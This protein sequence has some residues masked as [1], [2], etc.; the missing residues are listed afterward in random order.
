MAEI[1]VARQGR[2]LVPVNDSDL[3]QLERLKHGTIYKA[4]VSAPRNLKRHRRFFALLNLTFG[5]WQPESMIASVEKST[6]ESLGKYLVRHGIAK[7]AV[8][9]LCTGFINALETHRQDCETSKDFDS[10][11]E[12]ITVESGF[13]KLVQSPAGVRKVA[14]SISFAN[15][16]DVEFTDFYRRVLNTCWQLCLHRIYENQDELANELLR[17]E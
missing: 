3:E 5:Y 9:A 16:D 10:F 6:V 7:D 17:F 14:N 11:R 12:W 13:Y 15:C 1:Y 8:D 2:S 4:E